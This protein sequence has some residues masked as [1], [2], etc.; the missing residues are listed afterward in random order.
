[1]TIKI[2]QDL[3]SDKNNIVMTYHVSERIRKRGITSKDIINAIMSGEII[4]DYPDDYPYPSAL[5]FG[6]SIDERIIHVV[7]GV[8]N[9]MLWIITSY[10]PNEE[11]WESDLK[12][13]KAVEQ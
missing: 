9:G 2:M 1:M 6:Y 10:F 3:C 8:G 11:K 12:T 5:V 13:R 4:E 7:A